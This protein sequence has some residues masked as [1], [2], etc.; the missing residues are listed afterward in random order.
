MFYIVFFGSKSS[1]SNVYFRLPHI[2]FELAS[3]STSQVWTRRQYAY[4]ITSALNNSVSF[5]S[6]ETLF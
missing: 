1:K 3:I 6:M 4:A 5:L 2:S